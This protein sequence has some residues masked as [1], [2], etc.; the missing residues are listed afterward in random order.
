M[1]YYDKSYATINSK[2]TFADLFLIALPSI[3]K[4]LSMG[5]IS[6]VIMDVTPQLQIRQKL[7]HFQRVDSEGVEPSTSRVQGERSTNWAKS[8]LCIFAFVSN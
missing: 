3:K 2:S 7:L 4:K 5:T 1:I 8:P 6:I